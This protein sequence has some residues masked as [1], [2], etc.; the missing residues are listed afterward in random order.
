MRVSLG[1]NRSEQCNQLV[2]VYLRAVRK[3]HGGPIAVTVKDHA[4]I[5]ARGLYR[6][7]CRVHGALVLRIWDMVR[8]IS[9]RRKKHA[10]AHIRAERLENL[11]RKETGCAVAGIDRNLE[12]FKHFD[13]LLAARLFADNVAHMGRIYTAK[14]KIG[15]RRV[16]LIG[17]PQNAVELFSGE[18]AADREELHAVSLV[19]EVA[20]RQHDGTVKRSLIQYGRL[21][22]GRCRDEPAAASLHASESFQAGFF[23]HLRRNAA[24]MPDGNPKCLP[25]HLRI[26]REIVGKGRRN[27]LDHLRGQRNLL[28][29]GLN[30]RAAHIVPVLDAQ[31]ILEFQFFSLHT[32][33]FPFCFTNILLLTFFVDALLQ[34]EAILFLRL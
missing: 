27:A 2:S 12:T 20:C 24:V 30:D 26:V 32:N 3:D 29:R 25:V 18:R 31:K 5:R 33:A 1:F 11:G 8:E 10:A 9:V 7:L 16:N 19:G 4:E 28:V 23:H 14:R 13:A 17:A 15:G 6:T 21:E 22:H 34:A